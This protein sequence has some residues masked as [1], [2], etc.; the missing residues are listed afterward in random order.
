M[1]AAKAIPPRLVED[2][3]AI[4]SPPAQT[5]LPAGKGSAFPV[6]LEPPAVQMPPEPRA[7]PVPEIIPPPAVEEALPSGYKQPQA[8]PVSSPEDMA[9][10]VSEE[11]PAIT[12]KPPQARPTL[13]MENTP[14]DN[15]FGFCIACGQKLSSGYLYCPRCGKNTKVPKSTAPAQPL[16][17]GNVRLQ[18]AVRPQN[19]NPSVM[20]PQEP[21]VMPSPCEIPSNTTEEPAPIPIGYVQPKYRPVPSRETISEA[22]ADR[23]PAMQSFPRANTPPGAP[24]QPAWSRIRGRAAQAISPVRDFFG[25]QWRVRKLYGKW[26]KEN[27]I[28]PEDVPSTADLK[29]IT[30]E[31]KAPAYQPVRM[32]YLILGAV[33]FVAFF[34]FIGV[35][36]TRCT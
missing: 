7:T 18:D 28:A 15:E 27:D 29:Q 11:P 34:I 9:N 26:T 17:S 3:T 36:M 21:R 23:A 24:S 1:L 19:E 6:N 4:V 30:Q 35:I 22:M 20:Q 8:G 5:T 12:Q 31:G 16:Q 10:M 32:V 14:A 13:H 25:G 2:G 33:A